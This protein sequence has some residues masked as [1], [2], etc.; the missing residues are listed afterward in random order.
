VELRREVE[1][2]IE[3]MRADLGRETNDDVIERAAIEEASRVRGLLRITV[4]GCVR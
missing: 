4:G 2:R 1:R 3:V